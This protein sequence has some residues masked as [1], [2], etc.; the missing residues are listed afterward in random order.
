MGCGG[1]ERLDVHLQGV[2]K[3]DPQVVHQLMNFAYRHVSEILQDAEVE[4]L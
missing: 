3:Y 1:V 2:F 4:A